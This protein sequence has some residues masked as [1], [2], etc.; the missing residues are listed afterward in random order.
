MMQ[1][2]WCWFFKP[3]LKLTSNCF[4]AVKEVIILLD[5]NKDIRL[6]LHTLFIINTLK[7]CAKN[8]LLP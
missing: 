1:R 2:L 4:T 3:K 5:V 6:I 7:Q 8:I